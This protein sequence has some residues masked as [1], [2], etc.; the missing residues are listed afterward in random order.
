[1]NTP[2]LQVSTEK[3]RERLETR[4]RKDVDPDSVRDLL[5]DATAA[6]DAV[7]P[8]VEGT[9]VLVAEVEKLMHEVARNIRGGTPL[10][11]AYGRVANIIYGPHGPER[12]M[13]PNLKAALAHY[14]EQMRSLSES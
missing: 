5:R 3:L 8:V 6:L 2:R 7:I 4:L 11:T 12:G 10:N 9:E 1:M 14:Q 13:L